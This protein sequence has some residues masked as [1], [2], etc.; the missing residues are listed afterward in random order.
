MSTAKGVKAELR[1]WQSDWNTTQMWW[2]ADNL[3]ICGLDGRRQRVPCK[4]VCHIYNNLCLVV[5]SVIKLSLSIQANRYIS[6]KMRDRK[7]FI[8]MHQHW[9]YIDC[10][11]FILLFR[12]NIN[13]VSAVLYNVAGVLHH[14]D[15]E[16]KKKFPRESVQQ[17]EVKN[18]R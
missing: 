7:I 8:Q 18:K 1:P 15:S 14:Y 4:C 3:K 9:G 6:L 5:V 17:R 16:Y 11:V 12:R 10:L 2:F 13:I